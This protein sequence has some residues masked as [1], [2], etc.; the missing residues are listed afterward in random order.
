MQILVEA[1]QAVAILCI[2]LAHEE[3]DC[4]IKLKCPKSAAAVQGRP[5]PM[6]KNFLMSEVGLGEQAYD[7]VGQMIPP[8]LPGS[9]E[10]LDLATFCDYF[11]TL[12]A[13]DGWV[14]LKAMLCGQA[15]HFRPVESTLLFMQKYRDIKDLLWGRK[16]IFGRATDYW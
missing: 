13:N 6:S 10:Y 8:K 11:I 5:A 2:R 16:C 1:R 15:P 7:R 12:T 3:Q 14:E 9:R 4:C